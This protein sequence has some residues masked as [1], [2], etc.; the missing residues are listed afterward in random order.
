M[1]KTTVYLAGG[2]TGLSKEEATQ[3]RNLAKDLLNSYGG[4]RF[5]CFSPT[6]HYSIFVDGN[7]INERAAM[8]Y[9]LYRLRRSDVVLINMNNPR[10]L[11]T[12]AEISL[13]YE[14]K[15]PMVAYRDNNPSKVS[16]DKIHPW[17]EC[18]IDEWFPSLG[19]AVDFIINNY[20][21]DF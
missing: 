18:M 17:Q 13:A 9:D 6:D 1:Q 16:V 11:G 7:N 10:S 21:P 20:H 14:L 5:R 3:W 8:N 2:I 4:G 12:M 19:E 15:I